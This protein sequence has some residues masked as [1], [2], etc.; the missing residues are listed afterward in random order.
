MRGLA[1]SRDASFNQ[2]EQMMQTSPGHAKNGSFFR[3]SK[4]KN[5][6][7]LGSKIIRVKDTLESSQAQ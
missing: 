1:R 6:H 7:S 2:R 5:S 4:T 3:S